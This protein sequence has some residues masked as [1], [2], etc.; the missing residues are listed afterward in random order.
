MIYDFSSL[1]TE[2]GN[3]LLEFWA[4]R[5]AAKAKGKDKTGRG[6][7]TSG[8][9]LDPIARLLINVIRDGGLADADFY[10]NRRAALPG[11]FRPSKQWDLVVTHKGK[12]AIIVELKSQVGSY[13]NNFNNRVEEALGS[14]IDLQAAI[15]EGVLQDYLPGQG[16]HAPFRGWLMVLAEEEGSTRPGGSAQAL[17]PIDEEFL[18]GSKVVSY[19]DRYRK[20]ASRL[21]QSKQYDA[22]AIITA[23]K[24]TAEFT[25]YGLDSLWRELVY[26]SAKLASI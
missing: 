21:V 9:H 2:L 25:G 6:E 10:L 11:Y 20:F 12:L 23:K 18:N 13:G 24:G 7:S 8:K 3:A 16:F 4:L 22:A 5:E 26:F 19:S 15:T 14:A 1:N 17:F